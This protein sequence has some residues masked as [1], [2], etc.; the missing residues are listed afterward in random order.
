MVTAGSAAASGAIGDGGDQTGHGGD[1]DARGGHP[2]SARQEHASGKFGHG[3]LLFSGGRDDIPL[4]RGCPPPGAV[5][6]TPMGETS[7]GRHPPTLGFT[8]RRRPS[9]IRPRPIA[10]L[11]AVRL[12][13]ARPVIA[14]LAAIAFVPLGARSR[15]TTWLVDRSLVVGSPR[16]RGC[17]LPDSVGLVATDPVRS[18]VSHRL[19]T[20]PG[21]AIPSCRGPR[22]RRPDPARRTAL[23]DGARL[24]RWRA[25]ARRGSPRRL[26]TLEPGSRRRGRS[27]ESKETMCRTTSTRAHEHL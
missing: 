1:G 9:P 12:A 22:P 7:A 16:P 27:P 6:I 20:S 26:L 23:A 5:R 4:V 14:L 17:G 15:P 24:R 13:V 21:A 19:L 2:G 18:A 3:L 11:L 10:A 8:L 25:P